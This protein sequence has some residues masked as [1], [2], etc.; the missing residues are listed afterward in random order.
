MRKSTTG[1]S[2]HLKQKIHHNGKG[3]TR[4][5][6]DVEIANEGKG[7]YRSRHPHSSDVVHEFAKHGKMIL[8][9]EPSY[10]AA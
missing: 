8:S 9:I 10:V 3:D 5:F 6:W 1:R 4:Y 7:E 2:K